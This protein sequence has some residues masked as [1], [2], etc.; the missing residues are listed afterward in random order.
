MPLSTINNGDSSA[1]ARAAINAA[2]TGL[3]NASGPNVF[4]VTTAG[5]DTTGDGSLAKPF[6]TLGRAVTE[7]D[8]DPCTFR[9]GRGTFTVTVAGWLAN[10]VIIGEGWGATIV[11]ITSSATVTLIAHD[12]DVSI[13]ANGEAGATGV[14]GDSVMTG[15]LIGG[16]GGNASEI[17]F[18]GTAR[19]ANI[20][21]KG[22]VG[23]TGGAGWD[24][25]EGGSSNGGDGG[26][27]GNSAVIDIQVPIV[28]GIV[29][30]GAADGGAGGEGPNG[31]SNGAAG[32][33]GMSAFLTLDS[34]DIRSATVTSGISTV[35]RCCVLS[36]YYITNDNGGNAIY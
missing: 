24:D 19:G 8:G 28:I 2:I 30:N 9:I 6:L 31:G 11:E 22:G 17:T 34:C 5:N 27:G 29:D 7:A 1:T 16:L 13:D 23:G 25:G 12:C 33:A 3:N 18:K 26:P 4:H 36:S 14:A 21:A 15:G 20:T 10:Q 35:S 32:P